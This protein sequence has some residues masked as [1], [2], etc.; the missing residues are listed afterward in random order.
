[1]FIAYSNFIL[2]A[3][4]TNEFENL[5]REPKIT[6]DGRMDQLLMHE[7]EKNYWFKEFESERRF[8]V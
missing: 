7:N 3:S 5:P 2:R 4:C 8:T 1:M 6:E